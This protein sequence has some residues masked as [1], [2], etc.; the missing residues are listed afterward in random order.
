MAAPEFVPVDRTRLLRTYES[1]PRRP[2]PWLADRPGE[3]RDGQPDGPELGRPG[4]DQGYVYLLA[5]Q[6]EGKL[7]LASG[8]HERDA[9]AGACA[10]ALRRA[11]L[12]GRAPIVHDLTV[13]LTIWGF[14]ALEVPPGLLALR[15]PLFE[16]VAHHH[17]YVDQR[18]IVD[19]VSD[20]A[21]R[22]TP[23]QVAEAHRADWRSL[24]DELPTPA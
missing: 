11:S 12:F 7:T 23:Q 13:A 22:M 20:R 4:P 6:F 8:E 21:L 1:P 18:R 2:E 15:R 19:L 16:E 24:L 3:L 14:L 10:V 9:L 5:R 17:H